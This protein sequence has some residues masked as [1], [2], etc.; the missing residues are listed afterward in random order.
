MI[1]RSLFGL[2]ALVSLPW[3]GSAQSSKPLS[4][5]TQEDY[6]RDNPKMPTCIDGK[7]FKMLDL[8]KPPTVTLLP[9]PNRAPASGARGTVRSQPAAPVARADWRFSHASPALLVRGH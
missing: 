9:P 6:C 1:I 4:Y 3:T 8:S 7:P 2:V 5:K